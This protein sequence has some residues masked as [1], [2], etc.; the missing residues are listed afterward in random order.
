LF[1]KSACNKKYE[2]SK[3]SQGTILTLKHHQGAERNSSLMIREQLDGAHYQYY[4]RLFN[5]PGTARWSS[6]SVLSP[7]I[8]GYSCINLQDI[9]FFVYVHIFHL[10]DSSG[11]ISFV[12]FSIFLGCYLWWIKV[13][14]FYNT[15]LLK[16]TTSH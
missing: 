3:Q 8:Y 2:I 15:G 1:K 10:L 12:S 5:D 11:F 16:M 7:A 6:L 14:T 4:H 9:W 13:T